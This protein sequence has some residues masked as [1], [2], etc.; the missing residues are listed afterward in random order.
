MNMIQIL[1][2]FIKNWHTICFIYGRRLNM[3]N[4]N[5]ENKNSIE[6]IL[7]LINKFDLLIKSEPYS[8]ECRVEIK[9]VNEDLIKFVN[10][11]YGWVGF[12]P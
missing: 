4:Q 5:L 7:I 9:S 2:I 3:N 6:E 11:N 12:E 8:N 10:D 1:N